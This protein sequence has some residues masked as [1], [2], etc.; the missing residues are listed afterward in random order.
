MGRDQPSD[1][2]LVREARHGKV[3]A[4][5]TLLDRHQQRVLRVLRLLA[6]PAQDR[7]DVAQEVFIRVFRHLR[8][9]RA[10]NSFGAWLYRVTVNAAHDYR[11]RR[12]R[13]TAG[14][15]PLPES[16][17]TPDAAADPLAAARDRE[18]RQALWRAM[19][20]LSER[21]RA[22][23]VLKEMEGLET[24]EIA[25]SLGVS[26]ITVRRHLGLARRRLRRCLARMDQ[27]K[28]PRTVERLLGE[29]G[30]K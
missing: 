24:A 13:Q 23:F 4:F 27:K 18:L 2:D 28:E 20:D 16:W 29:G 19:D 21:E 30:S 15:L 6:V 26:T 14:E 11:G 8:G 1:D 12:G 9:F 5:E 25:R 17:E 10:G 22:V 3:R 7:E